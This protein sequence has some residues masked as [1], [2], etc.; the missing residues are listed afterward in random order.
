MICLCVSHDS[1]KQVS[2]G[3]GSKGLLGLKLYFVDLRQNVCV[4]VLHVNYLYKSAST[5]L[6]TQIKAA[7]CHFVAH[8]QEEQ[9]QTFCQLDLP[10]PTLDKNSPCSDSTTFLATLK[11]KS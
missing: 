11:E 2:Q 7:L 9:D 8:S 1:R 6:E 4:C 3:S 10:Q 5:W